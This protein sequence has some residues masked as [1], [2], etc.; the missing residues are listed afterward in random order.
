MVFF[1]LE[2][3]ASPPTSLQSSSSHS[4][5][6][7]L[8]HIFDSFHQKEKIKKRIGINSPNVPKAAGAAAGPTL[9]QSEINPWKGWHSTKERS[10]PHFSTG[11]RTLCHHLLP[12]V[13][14]GN[15][16]AGMRGEQDLGVNT[17][18]NKHEVRENQTW[19]RSQGWSCLRHP[20]LLLWMG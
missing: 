10:F 12:A 20:K 16:K 17:N 19:Q 18:K 15:C 2:S 5:F 9:H 11:T 8:T 4:G 7:L 1:F 3:E 13:P 6:L 14:S